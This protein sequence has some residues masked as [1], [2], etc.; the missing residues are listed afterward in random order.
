MPTVH[1][2][3]KRQS[4]PF[5]WGLGHIL[6]TPQPFSFLG[7]V[8]LQSLT[9]SFKLLIIG[10]LWPHPA[11]LSPA[12][13]SPPTSASY[14]CSILS[15]PSAPAVTPTC[16]CS[17]VI[18][19]ARSSHHS[20]VCSNVPWSSSQKC[21]AQLPFLKSIPWHSHHPH[22]SS[23]PGVFFIIGNYH[24]Y[25]DR[26]YLLIVCWCIGICTKTERPIR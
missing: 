9:I 4:E 7:T 8:K 5:K 24:W 3:H 26:F 14:H 16:T 2:P 13:S 23:S 10:P 20:G 1:Y 11:T 22:Q 18:H 25:Y 6:W 19:M 21:H 17:P 12:H 15:L